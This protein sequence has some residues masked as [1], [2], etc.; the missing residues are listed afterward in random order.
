ADVTISGKV[1]AGGDQR[2]ALVGATVHLEPLADLPE[3]NVT[4]DA[5][6]EFSAD[7]PQ[8][9]RPVQ[10]LMWASE[11]KYSDTKTAFFSIDPANPAPAKQF[12][13]MGAPL[14]VV[15]VNTPPEPAPQTPAAA[16][17]APAAPPAA[18]PMAAH[19][20]HVAFNPALAAHTLAAPHGAI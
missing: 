16:T 2:A 14:P 10:G 12:I 7:F 4:S 8:V 1:F 19:F 18:I 15:A 3:H 9:R 5:N 20:H 11:D 13:D 17:P 6:G